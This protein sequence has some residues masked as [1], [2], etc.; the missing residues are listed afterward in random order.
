MAKQTDH[1]QS[2][3]ASADSPAQQQP[4]QAVRDLAELIAKL[5]AAG[6]LPVAFSPAPAT[7]INTADRLNR[8]PRVTVAFPPCTDELLALI[9]SADTDEI[10][11]LFTD[12]FAFEHHVILGQDTNGSELSAQLPSRLDPTLLSC[13]A[14]AGGGPTI[15][16]STGV[17]WPTEC[18]LCSPCVTL[19]GARNPPPASF[20]AQPTIRRLFLGDALWMYYYERMGVHQILGAILDAYATTGRLPISNGSLLAG[21]EDDIIALV[22]EVMVRQTKMGMSSTVRD[23]AGVYRTALGWNSDGGRKLNI[24]SEVNTGFNTLFHKFIYHALEFYRDKRLAV[25]IQGAAGGVARPSVATLITISETVEVLKKRFEAFDYGRNYY[26]TL[27]GI[28]WTVAGLSIVRGLVDAL[29]IPRTFGD[30]HEF[31]PAAYDLLVLK[32]PVTHGE[33]NRFI[34]HNECARNGRNI[35]LDLEVV[36]HRQAA[37]GEELEDWLTQVESKVEAYR[38]AY[39]TLTGIDLGTAASQ[40]VEQQA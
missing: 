40:T 39:R 2:G 4:T 24:D 22:L 35:L 37:P 27:A 17:P 25:A 10:T 5:T 38:T 13:V 34:V 20:P 36:N 33:T 9:R 6:G 29:G 14:G 32:R 8:T 1:P 3:S 28:V 12:Y 7:R 21:I 16:H 31:V 18:C 19:K 26:N 11:T 15:A 23:R 30:A